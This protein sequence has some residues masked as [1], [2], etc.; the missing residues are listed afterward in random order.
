MSSRRMPGTG[1]H[2]LPNF[3]TRPIIFRRS[4]TPFPVYICS[5]DDPQLRYLVQTAEM[6]GYMP[7]KKNGG[8]FVD[9]LDH[10]NIFRALDASFLPIDEGTYVI[11]GDE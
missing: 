6:S 11:R 10:Y 2:L 3:A 9:I 5:L 7:Y 1:S 8:I 4:G